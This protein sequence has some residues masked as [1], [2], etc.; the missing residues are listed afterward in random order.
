MSLNKKIK[1]DDFISLDYNRIKDEVRDNINYQPK[2]QTIFHNKYMRLSIITIL[3]V[4]MG[5][6]SIIA[7]NTW[8][9]GEKFLQVSA[10]EKIELNYN[11]F[12]DEGYNQFLKKMNEFSAELSE[13]IY[14]N[15]DKKEENYVISPVS[16]YMALAMCV[17]SGSD[18]IREELLNALGMTYEEV[19]K[20]TKVLFS[21]LNDEASAKTAFGD[22]V[23]YREIMANSIWIDKYIK[24][25]KEGLMELSRN[26]HCSSYSV[27]FYDDN[28]KANNAI[29][30]YVKDNTKGLIDQDFE[31]SKETLFTLINTYYL[32]DV[33]NY[34]GEELQFG[35]TRYLFN[36]LI[37]TRLL[38]GYYELGRPYEADKYT[39]FYTKTNHNIKIKFIV[40]K[41]GY[42]I[43]D[44]YTSEVLKEV[45]SISDYNPYDDI[46]QEKYITRCLFP[47]FE[48]EFNYDIKDILKTG[49]NINNFFEFGKNM[50]N[51]TEKVVKCESIQHVTKLRVD[52]EGIEGSAATVLPIVGECGPDSYKEICLDY[53][54]DKNFIVIVT[55]SYDVP[56]FSG[57]IYDII[58]HIK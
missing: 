22:K 28:E 49:F 15:Y 44:I 39:H 5:L 47:M 37:E 38:E 1:N 31:I 35:S 53:V 11:D 10:A 21:S 42:T 33:W 16:I 3:V 55:D 12:K 7:M 23:M 18:E 14:L 41:E 34:E 57:V 45:N 27:P 40:P 54:V 32:K 20:Y 30:E 6:F 25:K 24:L 26:Y 58:K 29:R 56:L 4:F 52:E 8:F 50:T 2:K 13:Q 51:L 46:K 9:V 17:E 48:A 36:N 43:N 19:Y